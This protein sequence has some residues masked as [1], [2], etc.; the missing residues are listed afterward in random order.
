[1]GKTMDYLQWRGDLSFSK[2]PFNDVDALILSLLSYLPFKDIV[3]DIESKE[4]I[5]LKEASVQ[6][7][8]QRPKPDKPSNINP[9]ASSTFDAELVE[10]LKSAAACSRFE[11]VGLSRYD[12]NT[13][14]VIGRQFA[15][16]T[17]ILHNLEHGKVVAFR[18]TDNSLVGW[19]EDFKLSYMEQIP[20]QESAC[21]YL[22]RTIGILSSQFIVCGHS[23]GGNL[24]VYAGSHLNAA[25][26]SRLTKI[27]NFDG[28]GFDFSIVQR[29]PFSRCE[30]K[31]FSY[32][33]EESM[34]GMLLE[35]VG[36]R[37]VVASSGRLINQHNALNWE[38]ERTKF[39]HGKLSKT[40]KLMEQTLKTWLTEISI[41]EREMFLEALFDMLGASEGA[42]IKFDPQENLKEIKN[43]LVKYTKLDMKTKVFLAQVFESLSAETRKTLTA[44]LKEKLPRRLGIKRSASTQG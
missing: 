19:K 12:E 7:F 10:L 42:A 24:A 28:P 4:E 22:E 21:N 14:F 32:V 2:D 29:D 18:G 13:D 30:H 39:V 38:V 5:T 37:T 3:P 34:V 43:I 8:S 17:F 16:L 6:Y 11:N 31:V 41:S 40:A 25:R 36:K 35:P 15:A 33:P 20:G 1:M 26:Q 44:T 9:T 23:K 27:L